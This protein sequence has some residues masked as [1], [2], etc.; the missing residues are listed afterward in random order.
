MADFPARIKPKKS[1]VAGETPSAVDLEVAEIAVNTAD[2]KLFVKHT[3][4]SIKE[5]SGTGGGSGSSDVQVTQDLDDVAPITAQLNQVLRYSAAELA[6]PEVS[7]R[8]TF[9][10][11]TGPVDSSIYAGVASTLG[12]GSTSYVQPG[13]NGPTD[14][15]M[16]LTGGQVGGCAIE[17]G[18]QFELG[19]DDFT[20]EAWIYIDEAI[21]ATGDIAFLVSQR[22]TYSGSHSFT[23]ALVNPE[24][25]A[26]AILLVQGGQG[27]FQSNTIALQSQTWHHVAVTKIGATLT[28]HFDGGFAGQLPLSNSAFASST[29]PLV[30]GT[31]ESSN[32]LAA[33]VNQKIDMVR[34]SK[35]VFYP[36]DGS[37]FVPSLTY[38]GLQAGYYPQSL[39]VVSMDDVAPR[40]ESD[41]ERWNNKQVSFGGSSG[42]WDTTNGAWYRTGGASAIAFSDDPSTGDYNSVSNSGYL[43]GIQA[44]DQVILDYQN[45]DSYILTAASAT[46]VSPLGQI[47][48]YIIP[49]SNPSAEEI[50]SIAESSWVRIQVKVSDTITAPASGDTLIWN[51]TLSKWEQTQYTIIRCGKF[52]SG[53]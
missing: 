30:C 27:N 41:S 16:Q 4:G 11:G 12:S 38:S 19:A 46:A 14:F 53:W 17:N 3:D 52:G 21:P 7:L 35:V 48:G 28:F 34:L 43:S 1:S 33:P 24:A 51:S 9:E 40:I 42:A 32:Y 23:L 26:P 36:T 13:L 44:G 18:D 10:S 20:V 25:S 22:L 29:A 45:G 2:G 31:A 39:T 49:L 6:P 15:C 47:G 5:I 37:S 50:T 8:L